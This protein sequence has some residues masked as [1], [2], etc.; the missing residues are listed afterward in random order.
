MRLFVDH[1]T[2]VDFSY[3]C[4][5]R[6]VVGET[7]IANIEMLGDLNEQGMVCD[8]GVVKH[9]IR[10]WLDDTLDHKLAAPKLNEQ[11]QSRREQTS[12]AFSMTYSSGEISS[13]CPLEAVAEIDVMHIEKENVA[14]WCEERL[15][16]LFPQ[17]V[18]EIKVSFSSEK[19][20]GPHYHYSHGL[21]KHS[22]H[23]QRI[24]HG[25]RSKILIW[26]NGALAQ[27]QMSKW[28][29]QWSDIYIGSKEDVVEEGEHH[30]TF[31]Y[32]ASQG[33]F[34]LKLPKEHC[35]LLDSDSTVELIAEHIAN[36]LKAQN[37]DKVYRVK[38][39]EGCGKGAIAER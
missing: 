36:T 18:K 8:F 20:V 7:W 16:E 6:G 9:Q 17:G 25:H 39:F 33:D 34:M 15:L 14:R 24:A 37:P 5:K 21:K 30:I 28:A 29:K 35:Y 32:A 3:L 31:A 12:L 26:E 1:L 13:I 27:E 10:R 11:Y 4:C 2:N 38:A 23:C 22:G 19:I